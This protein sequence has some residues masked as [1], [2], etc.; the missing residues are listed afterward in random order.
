MVDAAGALQ[1]A[2]RRRLVVE[3]EAAALLAARLPAAP[4]TGSNSSASSRP[5]AGVGRGAVGAD[6]V[7]ALQRQLGRDLGVVGDQRLVGDLDH[8]QLVLEALGVGE[9]A[10][11]LALALATRSRWRPSRSS[12]KSSASSEPTRQT[13]RWT[14]PAPARPCGHARGT[15]RR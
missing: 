6:R 3:V 15:R 12:Q 7:E 13:I 5:A 8:E 2:L 4:S 1:R 9:D 10:G 11:A 14:S